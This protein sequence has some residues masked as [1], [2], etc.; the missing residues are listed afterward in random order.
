[1]GP[2]ALGADGPAGTGAVTLDRHR[3]RT[4]PRDCVTRARRGDRPEPSELARGFQ[5]H[6]DAYGHAVYNLDF[7][8]PVP[9]DEPAPV[10]DDGALLPERAGRRPVRAPAAAAA[11]ARRGHGAV[12]RRGWTRYAAAASTRCC[13]GPRRSRRSARTRS[14]TSAWPGRSCA[15]CCSSS[16]AGWSRRAPS[17]A[18][19]RLLVPPGR[20]RG[21]ARDRRSRPRAADRA[22]PRSVWRGQRRATPPQVLPEGRWMDRWAR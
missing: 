6:L 9:A 15:G 14:P 3:R 17:T 7:A 1:M 16:A 20:D 2:G 8:N 10:V 18:R 4:R 19:R 21:R 11:E 5:A 12:I 22:A 13:A